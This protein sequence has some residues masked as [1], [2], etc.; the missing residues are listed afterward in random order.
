VIEPL[1]VTK[2]EEQLLESHYKKCQTALIRTRAHALLLHHDG[3]GIPEI[4]KILRS[5]EKTVR[6]WIHT[7]ET[8]RISGIFPRYEGNT[9]ASKLT[10][11]QKEEIQKTLESPPRS[12]G[13]SSAFW[14]V[15]SLKEY[16][17]AHY[18]VVYE[19]DRSY[20]H[21]F[22]IMEYSFKLPEGK[23]YRRDEKLIRQRML[24]IQGEM[25]EKRKEGYVMFA[26]DECSLCWETIYR[27]AWIKK[28]EKTII[29]AQSDKKRQHYFGALN[30]NTQQ[31]ELVRLDWQD[32][33]NI[34]EALRE[35]TRRYPNQKICIIWDNA[36]WHR[37]KALRVY[38]GKGK[39]FEHIHFL[40]LPPYAPDENPQ[41]HVWRIGKD[42]VANREKNTFDEL[43]SLFENAISNKH[44]NYQ[45]R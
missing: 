26:A 45:I 11:K 27:R 1:H 32:T 36:K 18:G 19:S 38:L 20:H 6:S 29:K 12:D 44:F 9:N 28:G 30:L 31:H 3:Y 14:S 16:I 24:E 42:A 15:S 2:K 8:T 13:L 21:L 25:K 5:E 35:L 33:Q 23:N 40:W 34:I 7:F 37:S 17:T 10:K 4:A 22:A 43:K 39:E 41:E